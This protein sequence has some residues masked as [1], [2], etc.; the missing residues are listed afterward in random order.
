MEMLYKIKKT[1]KKKNESIILDL[2]LK[3]YDKS[4]FYFA[5]VFNKKIEKFKVLYVPLDAIDER[6]DVEEYFC[7]Q[8]I[9]LHTVN[10]ILESINNNQ[11]KFK[12][13]NFRLK[14]NKTM[15]AYYIELNLYD[16]PEDY[17]FTFSQYI[18]RDFVVL[19]DIIVV[20]F[21]HLPNIV[22]ELCNKLLIDFNE[23]SEAIKYTS[24]YDFNLES[25]NLADLFSKTVIKKN[26]YT[27]D[28]VEF[29]E[30]TG[31]RYYAVV[32]D[33]L[34]IIDNFSG[35]EILNV[36]CGELDPLGDEVCIVVEAIQKKVEKKFYRLKVTTGGEDDLEDNAT[37]Y[38][39]CY[40]IDEEEFKVVNKKD[41][42]D[43][44]LDLIRRDKVKILNSDKILE[45]KIKEYLATKYEKSRINEIINSIFVRES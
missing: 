31:N 43:V 35:K 25:G 17:K 16:I 41:D 20:L 12:D 30:N 45:N 4:N 44:S 9:F 23:N 34:I 11:E 3:N 6:D 40:G 36:S 32:N 13:E 33:N 38:Y 39:L 29:L 22:N 1:L 2:Y 28:D 7:Y 21:E 24:S 37:Y 15:D 10:Y 14:A 5:L 27:L 26:K 8:F 18:D 19:F 42:R